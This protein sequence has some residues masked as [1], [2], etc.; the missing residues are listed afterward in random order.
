MMQILFNQYGSDIDDID[1][2]IQG[3]QKDLRNVVSF[4]G[5]QDRD[6]KLKE[7]LTKYTTNLNKI[8]ESKFSRDKKAYD[9]DQAYK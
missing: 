1:K 8:K 9:N 4:E 3:W 5:Y 7:H 2:E 6:K